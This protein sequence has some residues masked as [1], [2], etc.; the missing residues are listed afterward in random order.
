MKP[1]EVV[2]GDS[3]LILGLPH[4]GTYLPEAIRA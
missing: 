1:V 3:P 4:T 2:R